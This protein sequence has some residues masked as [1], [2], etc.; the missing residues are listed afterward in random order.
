MPNIFILTVD[1]S[2]G[3]ERRVN[4][5]EFNV[6]LV[7]SRYVSSNTSLS[8]QLIARRTGT[9]NITYNE[10]KVYKDPEN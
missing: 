2:A 6:R 1:P 5:T 8:R 7:Y 10:E 3:Y 4:P 9:G